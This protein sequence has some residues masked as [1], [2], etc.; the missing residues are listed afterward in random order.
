MATWANTTLT[1]TTSLEAIEHIAN[2]LMTIDQIE[3]KITLAKKKLKLSIE[4]WLAGQGY[5]V[6]ESDSEILIDIISNP[7]NF[8]LSSDYL[9]LSLIYADL[10]FQNT[11]S[12][13]GAK[14]DYYEGEYEEAYTLALSG[15]N[16]D[17]DQDGTVDE[18]RKVTAH[19]LVL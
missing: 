6:D 8:G 17:Y 14:R 11:D 3:A 16:Y 7:E 1:T 19:T 18:Y 12:M 13:Y 5:K 10:F 15:L 9:T 4:K 2:D